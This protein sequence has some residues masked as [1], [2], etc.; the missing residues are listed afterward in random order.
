MP[1]LGRSWEVVGE[2]PSERHSVY[3]VIIWSKRRR[4]GYG[5]EKV[6]FADRSQLDR[7]IQDNG[8]IAMGA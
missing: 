4:K 2:I 1:W 5:Y 8:F 3:V 7:R 6:L